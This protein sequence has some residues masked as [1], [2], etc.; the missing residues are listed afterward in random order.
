MET[1]KGFSS[2]GNRVLSTDDL[3]KLPDEVRSKYELFFTEFLEMK[4]LYETQKTSLG[5]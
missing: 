5:K 3:E 2:F 4:A 1:D